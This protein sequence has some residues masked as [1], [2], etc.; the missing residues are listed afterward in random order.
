MQALTQGGP[1]IP[2]A[3]LSFSAATQGKPAAVHSGTSGMLEALHVGTSTI[4]VRALAPDESL[5]SEDSAPLRVVSLSS[6]EVWVPTRKLQ[7]GCHMPAY[8]QGKSETGELISPF[9]VATLDLKFTWTEH[10][11]SLLVNSQESIVRVE[12]IN[13]GVAKLTAE[14][15]LKDGTKFS[16]A[17]Q[18][19]VIPAMQLIL[20]HPSYAAQPIGKHKLSCGDESIISVSDNG[21]VTSHGPLGAATV[22]I[23]DHKTNQQ[24]KVSMQVVPIHYIMV[25]A[26]SPLTNGIFPRGMRTPA[27]ITFHDSIGREILVPGSEHDLNTMPSRPQ[28]LT[29]NQGRIQ[30][31]EP[32][33]GVLDLWILNHH[34]YITLKVDQIITPLSLATGDHVCYDAGQS[35]D[36]NAQPASIL[37]IDPK[38]GWA[39][40]HQAGEINVQLTTEQGGTTWA[41]VKVQPA[42][43]VQFMASSSLAFNSHQ[44][45][46]VPFLIK[47]SDGT[48]DDTLKA[49]VSFDFKT[50]FYFCNVTTGL[51]EASSKI[52]ITACLTLSEL[53]SEKLSVPFYRS[54]HIEQ[55][56][57]LVSSNGGQILVR[58]P[59]L[60]L[61]KT[62]VEAP[63]GL[64][65]SAPKEVA[66]GTLMFPVTL[67]SLF[68]SLPNA[69]K[70]GSLLFSVHSPLTGQTFHLPVVVEDNLQ[71]PMCPRPFINN[72]WWQWLRNFRVEILVLIC[73]F[74]MGLAAL[75]VY[76]T[77]FTFTKLPSTEQH[78]LG[79]NMAGVSPFAPR[80]SFFSTPDGNGNTSGLSTSGS[81]GTSRLPYAGANRV[82]GTPVNT[83]WQGQGLG[84]P[85]LL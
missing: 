68:W 61:A 39:V 65:V 34:A 59:P 69:R 62:K 77:S 15:V 12:A 9:V 2:D 21:L 76:W 25:H 8:I 4:S 24:L 60:P 80:R 51:R 46:S 82:Y 14:V 58:G 16:N 28:T 57:I 29:L 40:G 42:S 43:A 49:S 3:T 27:N 48:W 54:I 52:S 74:I 36:W 30:L 38:S 18:I 84:S 22:T 55:Q 5:Y 72:S 44:P 71:P 67:S 20:P 33:R 70:Y 1:K 41:E 7:Q 26:N 19:E 32:G 85:R 50:G 35:G 37:H 81:E 83:S 66:P 53:C 11:G 23:S 79:Q 45:L 63:P 78:I 10:L 31:G 56:E 64:E 47:A 13:I 6:I 75:Y 73:S 17:I